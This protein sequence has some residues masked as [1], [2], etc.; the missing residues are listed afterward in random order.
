MPVTAGPG[1]VANSVVLRDRSEFGVEVKL[2]SGWP[3]PIAGEIFS[4]E[5]GYAN[6]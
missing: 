2:D 1:G 3:R 5:L 6:R 4:G